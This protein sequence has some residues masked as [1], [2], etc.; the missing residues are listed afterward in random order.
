MKDLSDF[1]IEVASA[2]L[3]TEEGNYFVL[4]GGAA[5][6]AHGLTSRKTS[7]LDFF[8]S[9][10]EY[11]IKAGVSR[12]L[13]IAEAKNWTVELIK[14]EYSF[15]RLIVTGSESLVVDLAIDSAL[16]LAPVKTGIGLAVAPE[17]L[18][19]RKLLALFD[20]ALARDFVDVHTLSHHFHEQVIVEMALKIDQG[21]DLLVLSQMLDS[22]KRF[23]DDE[24]EVGGASAAE[25]KTFFAQWQSRIQGS[26]SESQR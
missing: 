7:D 5:L 1:Q 26:N 15:H 11:A 20:R 21:F 9:R 18:A 24:L 4:A 13:L 2:F 10:P 25:V 8:T 23:Q 14:S 6:L 16:V 22:I 19:G 17:E 3:N 12:L